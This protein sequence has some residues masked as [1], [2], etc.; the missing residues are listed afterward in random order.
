MMICNVA[1]LALG[2]LM[3]IC[4]KREIWHAIRSPC[5]TLFAFGLL[6]VLCGAAG[7]WQEDGIASGQVARRPPGKG[8]FQTEA[9]ARLEEDD[10][11]YAVTLVIPEQ[12]Y[13]HEKEQKLLKAAV[14]EMER[15]FCG[16]NKSLSEISINPTV[17]KEYQNGAV[18]AEWMFSERGLIAEDGKLDKEAAKLL[19]AK[20][21]K[22]EA[23]VT[24]SCGKSKREHS[25]CFWV[26]PPKKSRKEAI[27][28]E[29]TAQIASQD[30]TEG[31]VKLPDHI[32]GQAVTWRGPSGVHP[33]ELLGLGAL[34]AAAVFYSQ[35]ER[36]KQ[37]QEKRKRSLLL[38]YPEFVSKLSLLLGAGMGISGALRK[39]DQMYAAKQAKGRKREEAYEALHRMVCEMDNGMGELRAYQAFSEDCDLQPYRKLTSLLASAQKV[40]NRRL[41]EQ[42]N[43]EAD[44]VFAERKNAAKRLGE[45]AG[46]KL[47]L[48]MMLLLMIVMG[49]VMIPAFLSFYGR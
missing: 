19:G 25:F 10:A 33:Q 45:E 37:E 32:D 5:L 44:R 7:A 8:D 3:C 23:F 26:V 41:L 9:Y 2:V 35:R 1:C 6:G 34:A 38:A 17:Q 21:Q 20:K 13:K 22:V 40:G 49:I 31:V 39:M 4:R 27:E 11:E 46:T 43:E 30:Q 28:L 47:L 12:T 48:P 14:K 18:T 15:T 29:I 42:L 16:S 24:F 36:Q